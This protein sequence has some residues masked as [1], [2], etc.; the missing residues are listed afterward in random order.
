MIDEASFAAKFH[1]IADYI[2][3]AYLHVRFHRVI[4]L[5][6]VFVKRAL[7]EVERPRWIVL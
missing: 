6:I 1:P 3:H 5:I 2:F 7:P 4:I